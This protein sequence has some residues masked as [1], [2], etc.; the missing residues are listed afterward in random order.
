LVKVFEYPEGVGADEAATANAVLAAN[1]ATVS[2][3]VFVG[4]A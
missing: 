3:A 2:S 1:A 4:G